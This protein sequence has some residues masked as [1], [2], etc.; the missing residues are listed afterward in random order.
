MRQQFPQDIKGQLSRGF[1]EALSRTAGRLESHVPGQGMF[2]IRT[3]HFAADMPSSPVTSVDMQI[4]GVVFKDSTTDADI[5]SLTSPE[6]PTY[7]TASPWADDPIR[8]AGR[9]VRP[10]HGT[11]DDVILEGDVFFPSQI[12]CDNVDILIPDVVYIGNTISAFVE[13]DAAIAVNPGEF[14]SPFFSYASPRGVRIEDDPLL[15]NYS[16]E[17]RAWPVVV[18]QYQGQFLIQSAPAFLAYSSDRIGDTVRCIWDGSAGVFVAINPPVE[19]IGVIVD[20]ER[21]DGAT[22]ETMESRRIRLKPDGVD[23]TGCLASCVIQVYAPSGNP[24]AS[25]TSG[26]LSPTNIFLPAFGCQQNGEGRNNFD[27][28]NSCNCDQ[29]AWFQGGSLFVGDF[30][31]VTYIAGMWRITAKR[32]FAERIHFSLLED[33]ATSDE[34][35][36]ALLTLFYRG[37]DPSSS[38]DGE[39]KVH[40]YNRAA[41]CLGTSY[42]YEGGYGCAG[43]AQYDDIRDKYWIDDIDCACAGQE[44]FSSATS[45]LSNVSSS[46]SK[47]TSSVSSS[48]SKSSS[49]SAVEG[50]CCGSRTPTIGDTVVVTFTN[51]AACICPDGPALGTDITLTCVGTGAYTICDGRTFSDSSWKWVFEVTN[52]TF[53]LQETCNAPYLSFFLG[54]YCC[55]ASGGLNWE[56]DWF[57]FIDDGDCKPEGTALPWVLSSGIGCAGPTSTATLHAWS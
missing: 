43:T 50:A 39:S 55:Q 16:T 38:V 23:G 18:N 53:L 51:V 22:L 5:E 31:T 36:E 52:G 28:A 17:Q 41:G 54:V 7:A 1:F 3:Q 24:T 48:S 35:A 11:Q 10:N 32:K 19:R 30:V 9:S 29:N 57:R 6:L 26:E 14:G 8:G 21:F 46:S 25:P 40:V 45:S 4:A 44:E 2:G 47:S 37:V 42:R 49:S 56:V 20:I 27:I 15:P 33:L 13:F 34:K 12:Q